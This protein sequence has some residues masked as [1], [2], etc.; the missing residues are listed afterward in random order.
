MYSA[1][2]CGFE[3]MFGFVWLFDV[4]R[5]YI[6]Q[7][8]ITHTN[9]H[10]I[11]LMFT[12]TSSLLLLGSGFQPWTFPFLRLPRSVPGHSD[13]NGNYWRLPQQSSNWL[14]E[15]ESLYGWQ[16]VSQ[17][18]LASSPFCGRLIRYYFLFKCLGLEF[19]VLLLWGAL[20]EE[21]PGLSFVSHSLVICL[22]VHLLFTFLSFTLLTY[23]YIYMYMVNVCIYIYIH[24]TIH[25]RVLYTRP[26]LVPARY[27]R[28]CPTTH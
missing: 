26:R 5:A 18:A 23:I 24:S 1:C 11:T 19:V 17:Y 14:Q 2:R 15:S 25:I 13:N 8:K 16:S 20:F 21:R 3:L 10:K 12:V 4:A 27:S 22:C 9:K 6:L 7:F 28:L